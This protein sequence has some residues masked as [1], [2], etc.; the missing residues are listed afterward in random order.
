M[1]NRRLTGK[2]QYRIE[3]KWIQPSL[4]VLQ[5]EE[6]WDDGVD[7]HN[8]MPSYLAGKRWRDA[9]PEDLQFLSN[10]FPERV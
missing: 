8:G 5:V 2:V 1:S 3:H 9:E 7:D 6:Q 10:T 4:V